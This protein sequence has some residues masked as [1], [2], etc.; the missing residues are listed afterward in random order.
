MTPLLE[1]T[2]ALLPCPFCGGEATGAIR[3]NVESIG[4]VSCGA[5]IRGLLGSWNTRHTASN[6]QE[7]L[8]HGVDVAKR[9]AR[10][11]HAAKSSPSTY[12]WFHS[13]ADKCEKSRALAR[14]ALSAIGTKSEPAS[15]D[16]WRLIEAAPTDGETYVLA[17]RAG[18]SIPFVA[19]GDEDGWF[20][21]NGA[22]ENCGQRFKPTH[23]MPLP[24]PPGTTNTEPTVGLRKKIAEVI[25]ER[26]GGVAWSILP[27][28]MRASWLAHADAVIAS[29]KEGSS[30]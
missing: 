5:S 28:D 22:L 20:T 10:A 13:D 8:P 7:A 29:I 26:M 30:K 3:G 4:C 27:D 15:G 2:H 14:A 1:I 19:V 25:Y 16:G 12:P 9:V 11:I 18:A 17:M 24:S 23:W 6:N 21:F